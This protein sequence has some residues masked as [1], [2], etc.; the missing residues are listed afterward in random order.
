VPSGTLSATT[1]MGVTVGGSGTGELTLSGSLA[2]IN[3]FVAPTPDLQDRPGFH[4]QR[5][6]DR[7][8]NDNGFSGS[9]GEKTD[10]KT[11]TLIVTAV[12]DAPV[13]NVPG[14]QTASQNIA[15]GFNTANGNAISI[16]DVDSG[17]GLMT[18]TL[19]AT[20]GTS[21]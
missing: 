2:D 16:T 18:V 14:A 7:D 3:P 8:L 19:T 15:L 1:G 9:G 12:N 10:T 13:N 17:N 5:D 11:V 6:P 20:N 21:A 4:R